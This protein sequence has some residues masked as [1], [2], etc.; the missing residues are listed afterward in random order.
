MHVE[1]LYLLSHFVNV[2]QFKF[3]A[4]SIFNLLNKFETID[5]T[6]FI[7]KI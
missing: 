1:K 4:V 7:L 3:A 5:N 6:F 2:I